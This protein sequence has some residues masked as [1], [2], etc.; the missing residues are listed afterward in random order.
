MSILN[1]LM[2]QFSG[3]AL[4]ALSQQLGTDP[5]QT[6]SAISAALPMIVGAMA[7]QAST[8]EG[9]EALHQDIAQNHDGSIM[10]NLTGF[11][12]STD[13][14]LGPAI[15]GQL[16]GQKQGHVEAGV[17]QV[18]GLDAGVTGKLL[19]NLAPVVMGM[20]GRQQ[21]GGG[22]DIGG[23]ASVLMNARGTAQQDTGIAGTAMSMITNMLDQDRDGNPLDDIAGM[24]GNF[25][26]K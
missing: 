11:L 21:Q 22:M 20:L 4:D 10:D 12:S 23:L 7:K 25:L 19:E 16:F 26:K 3:P 6:Q 18:S 2:D 14:G 17:S 24:L 8:Q 13:N 15:L 5:G 9:A 1:E